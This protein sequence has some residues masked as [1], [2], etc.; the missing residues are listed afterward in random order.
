AERDAIRARVAADYAD[1]PNV[2]F[3]PTPPAG[4]FAT[5]Y[6]NKKPLDFSTTPPT[7]F[8]GGLADETD[9]RNQFLGGTAAIDI[10]SLGGLLGGP[11]Q[12]PADFAN[13]V[14]LS[15]FIAAHELGHLLGLKHFDSFGPIG[16]GIFAGV[17][18]GRPN[19]AFTGP[20]GANET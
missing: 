10:F 17:S 1:F 19:P 16:S 3:P 6:F 7:P 2:Q 14:S 12:P 4:T 20:A 8:R 13:I 18:P 5:L 9:F 15:A 11:G